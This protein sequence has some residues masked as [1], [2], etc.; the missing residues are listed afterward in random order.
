MSGIWISG[1]RYMRAAASHAISSRGWRRRIKLGHCSEFTESDMQSRGPT[2]LL[3]IACCMIVS[4]ARSAPLRMAGVAGY[5][6]EWELR[7]D[8]AEQISVGARRFSGSLIWKHVGL[9]SRNGPEE[10][11]GQID[12]RL[13]GSGVLS[14]IHVTLS[15]ENVSC[16]YN[17]S[18]SERSSGLMDCTDAKGVPLTLFFND[19]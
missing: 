4:P 1:R 10:K 5:L 15:Q 7:G 2:L 6:N 17:G 11:S 14:R 16:T 3:M 12:I 18:W 8:V 9:C 13:L 19:R